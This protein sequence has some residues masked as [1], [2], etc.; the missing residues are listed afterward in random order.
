MKVPPNVKDWL[1]KPLAV[2]HHLYPL[3]VCLT[4]SYLPKTIL[5]YPT[6]SYL[7]AKVGHGAAVWLFIN[8]STIAFR[9]SI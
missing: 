7:P 4:D 8:F 2:Y 5:P 1:D 6:K 9:S 3:L